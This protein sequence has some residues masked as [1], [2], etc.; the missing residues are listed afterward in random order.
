ME[1]ENLNNHLLVLKNQYFTDK[2][3]V[4]RVKKELKKID[5]EELKRLHKLLRSWCAY[6]DNEYLT[7]CS[8][9]FGRHNVGWT[10]LMLETIYWR[11]NKNVD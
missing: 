10:L 4:K 9:T 1:I 6:D 7:E 8:K 3:W 5:E 2:K 11:I